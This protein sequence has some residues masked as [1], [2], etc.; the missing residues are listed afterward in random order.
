[1]KAIVDRIEG[2]LAVLLL[3]PDEKIQFAVPSFI[4]QGLKEGDIVDIVVT[5]DETATQDAR[6]MSSDLIRKLRDEKQ[7]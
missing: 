3:E 2:D 6:A 7:V 1:M 4:L 5:R